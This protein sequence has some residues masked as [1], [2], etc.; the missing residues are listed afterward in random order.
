MN[1]GYTR[2]DYRALI[3]AF[4]DSIPD[5]VLTTDIIAGFP[6][7][8]EDEFEQTLD[9]VR[10]L[11]FDSAFTFMYTPRPGTLADKNFEDDVPLQTKKDRLSRLIELQEEISGEKNDALVGT[12]HEVLVEGAGRKGGTQLLGRTRG[13][14]IV[15]FQG[16]PTLIGSLVKVTI[17]EAWPHT[18]F[19]KTTENH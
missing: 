10:E 2:E 7:E 16:D 14:K 19:G 8:T 12:T 6:G 17:H 18:L 15:A 13:D 3:H 5:L 1:R 11:R 4:R 9:L